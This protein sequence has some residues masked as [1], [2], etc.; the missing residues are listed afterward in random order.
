MQA[1]ENL[2]KNLAFAILYSSNLMQDCWIV[3]LSIHEK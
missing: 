2:D 3:E 1:K